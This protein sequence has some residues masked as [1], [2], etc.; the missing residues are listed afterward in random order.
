[1]NVKGAK[2]RLVFPPS[3]SHSSETYSFHRGCAI[4]RGAS[5]FVRESSLLTNA[6]CSL[7]LFMLSLMVF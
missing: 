7:V 2:N 4:F 3:E 1:M 6:L 5:S